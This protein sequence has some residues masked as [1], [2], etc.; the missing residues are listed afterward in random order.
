[1]HRAV[2]AQALDVGHARGRAGG[3]VDG[4]TI[5]DAGGIHLV[6]DKGARV[7]LVRLATVGVPR[8][9]DGEHRR[10]GGVLVVLSLR[11]LHGLGA[12]VVVHVHRDRG[13]GRVEGTKTAGELLHGHFRLGAIQ[14]LELAVG[15]AGEAPLE[16]VI[17]LGHLCGVLHRLDGRGKGEDDVFGLVLQMSL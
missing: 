3:R 13:R 9:P 15:V 6:T 14:H 16:L 7:R 5:L 8:F 11:R 17:G 1:M 2:V 12:G 10:V 4:G